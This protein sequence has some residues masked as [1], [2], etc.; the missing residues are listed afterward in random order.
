[1]A[2]SNQQKK[3]HSDWPWDNL[4]Q[5]ELFEDIAASYSVTQ[6][7]IPGDDLDPIV[8]GKMSDH[9]IYL[10]VSDVYVHEIT[11]GLLLGR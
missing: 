9:S 8:T 5:A 11:Q 7:E 3:Q 4:D 10:R 6:E 1:M 2:A